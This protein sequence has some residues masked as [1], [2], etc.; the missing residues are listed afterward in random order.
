MQENRGDVY[1]GQVEGV[2]SRREGD[3]VCGA[4]KLRRGKLVSGDDKSLE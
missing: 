2:S 3:T 1:Q 4:T